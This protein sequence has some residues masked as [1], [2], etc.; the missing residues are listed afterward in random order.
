MYV[1]AISYILPVIAI[2]LNND[3]TASPTS[4]SQVNDKNV[5]QK[6][7]AMNRASKSDG[8]EYLNCMLLLLD[9]KLNL[10][11]ILPVSF[12]ILIIIEEDI[13]RSLLAAG[14]CFK[15]FFVRCFVARVHWRFDNNREEKSN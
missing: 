15:V 14:S 3:L 9:C 10:P 11:F 13:V 7:N 12:V 2:I 4:H 8:N 6:A 1:H 5:V